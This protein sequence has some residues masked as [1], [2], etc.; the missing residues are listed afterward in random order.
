M[1][2]MPWLYA[3]SS[4]P[5]FIQVM[6]PANNVPMHNPQGF[7]KQ[8][9]TY[10]GSSLSYSNRMPVVQFHNIRLESI[11]DFRAFSA[12]FNFFLDKASL[13]S[14]VA[15]TYSILPPSF[16][17]WD[18]RHALLLLALLISLRSPL[19][20]LIYL[21]HQELNPR[22]FHLLTNIW[23]LSYTLQKSKHQIL[24]YLHRI[25]Q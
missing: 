9:S 2:H 16:K 6:Y 11:S 8:G 5:M 25:Y 18:H 1:D 3:Y 23:P 21:W 24:G 15:H 10:L 20:S 22:P 4:L 19:T 7:T 14:Q 12:C 17:G 13:S